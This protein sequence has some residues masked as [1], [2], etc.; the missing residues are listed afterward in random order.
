[1]LL[2]S[3]AGLVVVLALVAGGAA[4]VHHAGGTGCTGCPSQESVDTAAKP[5]CCPMSSASCC[6]DEEASTE[7][8][9]AA[10]P[11]SAPTKA[12]ASCCEAASEETAAKK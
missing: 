7:S 2:K 3:V 9:C 10:C 1:M 11:T 12:K 6:Q 5:S 4:L 8:D